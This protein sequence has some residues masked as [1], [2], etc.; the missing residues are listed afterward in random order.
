MEGSILPY[1]ERDGGKLAPGTVRMAGEG[2]FVVETPGRLA[3]Y[4]KAESCLIRPEIGDSVLVYRDSDDD[5]YV[6]AVLVRAAESP[7]TIGFEHGMS[8][9]AGSGVFAVEAP[10]VRIEADRRVSLTGRELAVQA[11]KGAV[12]VETLAV[13]GRTLTA[14][15]EQARTTI[16]FLDEVR[17]RVVQKVNRCY[18]TVTEFEESRLGR[19][20]LLVAGRLSLRSKQASMLAEETV[21]ID[22]DQIHLG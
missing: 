8:L 5:G 1:P 3:Q 18:R 14:V 7:A 16:R 9:E 21:T 6:L 13:R 11:E 12:A 19:L 15:W 17:E 20:R 10:E 22:G 2:V 4:R